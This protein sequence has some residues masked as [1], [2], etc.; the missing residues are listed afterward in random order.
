MNMT[1]NIE[2]TSEQQLEIMAD[3][4]HHQTITQLAE[5]NDV[6][7][8]FVDQTHVE[9]SGRTMYVF[10]LIDQWNP[11]SIRIIDVDDL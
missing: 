3:S 4:P 1:A 8:T 9:L 7:L 2:L 11:I 6:R 10:E 5:A